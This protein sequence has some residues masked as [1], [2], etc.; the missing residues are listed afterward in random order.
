MNILKSFSHYVKV[1]QQLQ[2][3]RRQLS[4]SVL[5]DGDFRDGDTV[6]LKSMAPLTDMTKGRSG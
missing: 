2:N 6:M 3:K 5:N 1:S 4:P